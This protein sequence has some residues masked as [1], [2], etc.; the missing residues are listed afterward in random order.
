MTPGVRRLLAILLLGVLPLVVAAA[1]FATAHDSGSLA[2]DF[3][4]ELYPEAKLLLDWENPF[5]G[6]DDPL[7][8]GH[9]LIWP[10]I[11]AFLVAPLTVLSPLAADWVIALLGFACALGS[12]RIVG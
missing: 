3:H 7:Q 2:R 5:P 1:M 12:L 11:A 4:N 9:N 10:P 8:Y 6:P